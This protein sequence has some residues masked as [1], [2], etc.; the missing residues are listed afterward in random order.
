MRSTSTPAE[1]LAVTPIDPSEEMERH[2]VYKRLL[3]MPDPMSHPDNLG[4]SWYRLAWFLESKADMAVKALYLRGRWRE[5]RE[6]C[7]KMGE[8]AAYF[9]M[10]DWKA[11]Q[12]HDDGTIDPDAWFEKKATMTTWVIYLEHGLG[13]SAIGGH[14]DVVD[15]LLEFPTEKILADSDGKAPRSYYVGLARWWKNEDDLAW[16]EETKEI[17]G[18]GSK[19]IHLLCDAVAAIAARDSKALA[20]ALKKYIPWFLKQRPHDQYFPIGAMFVWHVA[21]RKGLEIDL[22]EDVDKFFFRLPEETEAAAESST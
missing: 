12:P 14:W 17:R 2:E 3:G 9:L 10:G 11:K 5:C 21:R 22:P 13:W 6:W 15:R 7:R 1:R 20:A 4:H 18:A 16:I 19:G 8:A